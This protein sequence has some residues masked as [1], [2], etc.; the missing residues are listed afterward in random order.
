MSSDHV[1]VRSMISALSGKVHSCKESLDAQAVGNGLYG[2]QGIKGDHC[3]SILAFLSG[4]ISALIGAKHLDRFELLSIGQAVLL[5]I[6]S[7]RDVLDDASYKMWTEL[8]DVVCS[9]HRRRITNGE[10]MDSFRSH[11]ERKMHRV[12]ASLYGQSR[13]TVSSNDYLFDMFEGDVVI[14]IPFVESTDE[15]EV[16]SSREY[17][18][19]NIEVDGMHHRQ[20]RKINFCKMRDVYLKSR[21]VVV[22]R[23]DATRVSK[24]D[25]NQLEQW[26]LD[27][28]AE[29]MLFS[30]LS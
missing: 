3:V 14:R 27:V 5:C 17:L 10:C 21:G 9:E 28:T 16:S 6:P 19:I 1:E 29:S 11:V 4:H 2:M 23:I 12:A 24:M 30:A 20:E 13:A 25:D 15:I 7:R 8:G 18:V 22:H 26:L